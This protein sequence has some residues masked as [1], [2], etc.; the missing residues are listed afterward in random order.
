VEDKKLEE[1]EA[2]RA[3]SKSNE[4]IASVKQFKQ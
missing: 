1:K 3:V 2:W 4:F